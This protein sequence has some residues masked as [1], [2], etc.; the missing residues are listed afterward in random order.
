M[1]YI[2]YNKPFMNNKNL[3]ERFFAWILTEEEII[4]IKNHSL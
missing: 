1:P 4:E 2:H 3:S